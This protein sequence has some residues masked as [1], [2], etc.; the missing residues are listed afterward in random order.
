MYIIINI[1][2]CCKSLKLHVIDFSHCYSLVDIP[3]LLTD[4]FS[5]HHSCITIQSPSVSERALFLHDILMKKPTELPPTKPVH[6]SGIKYNI[7]VHVHVHVHKCISIV[8]CNACT[9]KTVIINV[10]I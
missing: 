1:P 2:Y 7:Y 6:S 8:L 3:P 9:L 10:H 4:L 5:S